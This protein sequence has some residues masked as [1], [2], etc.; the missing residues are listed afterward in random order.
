MQASMEPPN[1]TAKRWNGCDTTL[2]ATSEPCPTHHRPR[3]QQEQEQEQ[4]EDRGEERE[5]EP[6]PAQRH[7]HNPASAQRTAV[8][9]LSQQAERD[10]KRMGARPGLRRRQC[11]WPASST[12][13]VSTKVGD[14]V[15]VVRNGGS[16]IERVILGW[17]A[18]LVGGFD[19]LVDSLLQLPLQPLVLDASS[20]QVQMQLCI[21]GPE[22]TDTRGPTCQ[23]ATRRPPPKFPPLPERSVPRPTHNP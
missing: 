13:L 7:S 4:E 15:Q 18:Y 3:Q 14:R 1:Q 19:A 12:T 10:S 23:D 17:S 6:P 16:E 21:L 11:R 9:A 5:R 2:T 22:P 20:L 8:N